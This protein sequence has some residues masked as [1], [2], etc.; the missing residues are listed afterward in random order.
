MPVRTCDNRL[1]GFILIEVLK[2]LKKE[3]RDNIPDLYPVFTVQEEVGCRGAK[4]AAHTINPDLAIALDITMANAFTQGSPERL[5][6]EAR[7]R[8]GD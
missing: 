1:L 6:S 2:K 8:T 4:V 7:K 3:D 5:H